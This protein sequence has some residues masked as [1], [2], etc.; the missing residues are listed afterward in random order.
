MVQA[1]ILIQTE[2]G[3]AAAVAREISGIPGVTRAEDVT[4]P[5]D[6]IVRAEANNV[7]E[8]GKLVVAQIQAVEGITRTL[9]CPIVHI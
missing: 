5:Y 4:G 1:Y 9:T 2:V 8:L 3:K 6:V 7:D